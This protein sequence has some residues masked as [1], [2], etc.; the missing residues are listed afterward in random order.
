MGVKDDN[1][2][3]EKKNALSGNAVENLRS[4]KRPRNEC[5]SGENNGSNQSG[6]KCPVEDCGGILTWHTSVDIYTP[7]LYQC[8]TCAKKFHLH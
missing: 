3:D 8:T 2:Q 7:W 6:A 1:L 5:R 4:S